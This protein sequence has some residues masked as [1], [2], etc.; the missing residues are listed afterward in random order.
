MPRPPIDPALVEQLARLATSERTSVELAVVEAAI[1]RMT[2]PDVLRRWS[3]D[4]FVAPSEV[5][6]RTLSALDAHLLARVPAAFEAL[7]LSPVAPLGTCAAVAPVHSNTQLAAARGTEVVA[8]CTN[9]LALECARRRAK[10]AETVRLVT[11]HRVVRG[12]RF[13][14]KG[15]SQHFRLLTLVTA[16][17]DAGRR[18]FVIDAVSEQ[19]LVLVDLLGSLT[20]LGYAT[21]PLTVVLSNDAWHAEAAAAIRARLGERVRISDDAERLGKS[22]YYGGLAFKLRATTP[23]GVDVEIGDGGLVDWV[24]KLRSDRKE[25]LAISALGTELVAKIH[26]ARPTTP[27]R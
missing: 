2:A 27:A 18:Q 10:S 23:A 4:A 24:A 21:A 6:Q 12:Q 15:Y 16:G 3:E 9:V 14:Q 19:I 22:S 5:D 8:D 1:R 26:R 13:R 25:R 7:E 20:S 11:S 17:R